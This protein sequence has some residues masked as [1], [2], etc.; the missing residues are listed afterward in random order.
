MGK[1]KRGTWQEDFRY[2]TRIGDRIVFLLD[3]VWDWLKRAKSFH[4]AAQATVHSYLRNSDRG[5]DTVPAIIFLYRHSIE[6]LLKSIVIVDKRIDGEMETFLKDHDLS[7]LWRESLQSIK[8]V[9]REKQNNRIEIETW[10]KKLECWD[11]DSMNS[12]YPSPNK[13]G[14]DADNFEKVSMYDLIA[15]CEWLYRRLYDCALGMLEIYNKM[16]NAE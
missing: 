7:K 5:I 14:R 4:D 15:T 8:N 3:N 9:Y 13:N 6:L 1:K 11:K 10:I 12:R 2:A 16:N